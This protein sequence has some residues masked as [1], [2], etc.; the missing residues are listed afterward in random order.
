M[1]MHHMIR[2]SSGQK[3][4]L[5]ITDIVQFH[6]RVRVITEITVENNEDPEPPQKVE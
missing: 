4:R 2:I 6:D 3:L 5:I 1:S